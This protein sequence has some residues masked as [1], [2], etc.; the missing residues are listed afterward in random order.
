[1][2]SKSLENTLIFQ[3]DN[4]FT[5]IVKIIQSWFKEHRNI[6]KLHPGYNVAC[7]GRMEYYKETGKDTGNGNE[8]PESDDWKN[9]NV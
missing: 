8:D 6:T 5:Q 2:T 9:Q 1:M 4:T 7:G 3:D